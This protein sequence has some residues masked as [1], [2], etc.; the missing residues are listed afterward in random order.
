MHKNQVITWTKEVEALGFEAIT[1]VWGLTT[2]AF[3]PKSAIT[4][5]RDCGS[6]N[7]CCSQNLQSA[8]WV[9]SPAPH[10]QLRQA[11]WNV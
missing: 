4:Q 10:Y 8:G 2:T 1:Q 5:G 7:G 6:C 9:S 11:S 3:V